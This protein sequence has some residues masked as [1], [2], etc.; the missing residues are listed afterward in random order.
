MNL[1]EFSE[2]ASKGEKPSGLTP[3]LTALYLDARGQW[4]EA[5]KAV[6]DQSDP[7]SSWVHAYLH[8]KEGDNGN[9]C[10]WYDRAGRTVCRL[11]FEKEWETMV[12][13]L[14]QKHG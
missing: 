4:D 11:S 2:S 8:R 1:E 10:Y 14:L 3:A 5:H 9:A 6:E 13:A 7:D 12:V